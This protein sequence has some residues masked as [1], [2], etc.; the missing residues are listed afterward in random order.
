MKPRVKRIC[1]GTSEFNLKRMGICS[2]C[3]FKKECKEAYVKHW[4]K[5]SSSNR[6]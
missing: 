2:G 4:G 6:E 1:F 5:R 3:P